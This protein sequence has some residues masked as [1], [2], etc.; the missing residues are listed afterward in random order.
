[1]YKE[2]QILLQQQ[3]KYTNVF[4]NPLHHAE[5]I[6][7]TDYMATNNEGLSCVD[8]SHTAQVSAGTDYITT[9][10][11]VAAT[12]ATQSAVSARETQ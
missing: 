7:V 5:V 11:T 3:M 9:D 8:K 10:A 6:A 4:L 2:E 12:N 1:M